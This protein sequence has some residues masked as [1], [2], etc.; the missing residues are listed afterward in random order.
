MTYVSVPKQFM[1]QHL[2]EEP[3]NFYLNGSCLDV[4]VEEAQ[5]AT[6]ITLQQKKTP[7]SLTFFFINASN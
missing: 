4:L 7:C 2:M 3:P 5:I 6:L 1:F